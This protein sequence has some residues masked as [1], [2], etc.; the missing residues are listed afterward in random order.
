MDAEAL[1]DLGN[2]RKAA[3]DL[4]GAAEHY[5]SALRLAP[6]Y[7]PALYNLGLVLRETGPLDE[8][9]RCFRAALQA[10]SREV[11]QNARAGLA[12]LA[13]VPNGSEA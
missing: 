8:A 6:G 5:R 12:A 4:Q 10:P 1:K 2:A 9:E 3:G 7:I 13:P 11:R